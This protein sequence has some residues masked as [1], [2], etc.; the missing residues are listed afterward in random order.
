MKV[1]I[2]G[3]QDLSEV[4]GLQRAAARADFYPIADVTMLG[5]ALPGAEVILGWSF[6]GKELESQWQ[7]ADSLRW[8]HWCGAGV[9]AALFDGLIDS[10]VILTNARG[11]FDRAMAEYVLGYILGE[12]KR[13]RDT[14]EAQRNHQWHY[15]MTEKIEGKMAAIYGVGS[16]GREIGHVLKSVGIEVI[17]VGRRPRNTDPVF[18]KIYTRKDAL[19]VAAAA[20][21]VIGVLPSTPDTERYFS[22]A[23]F[24]A[25]K[26]TARFINVGRGKTQDE[27][28]L[29][30][31][32]SEGRLA[33]AMLDVFTTEPVSASS[34]LWNTPN[35][36]ISAHMSG[37]FFG[38]KE[39][40]V[41]QFLDNLKRYQRGT[42]LNNVVDKTLGFVRTDSVLP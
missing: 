6:R 17:G 25:M 27:A 41:N 9:D 26:P 37:D 10:E 14:F 18:S 8:I 12:A 39:V 7:H 5:E 22:A 23:L 2:N 33:G 38:F 19:Q 4:P 34:P 21:W 11:V 36:V 13:F 24:D 32:L 40:L 35:L 29:I 30:K 15:Q 28:A 42:T 1:L 16:I 20:D 31:A 3:V